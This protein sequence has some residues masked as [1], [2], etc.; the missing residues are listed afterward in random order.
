MRRWLLILLL[1]CV[2]V[3]ADQA[4]ELEQQSQRLEAL[5]AEMAAIS[6]RLERERER[7]GGLEAELARLERRIGEERA[8]LAALDE[9]IRAQAQAVAALGEAVAEAE[10]QAQQ[11]RAFLAATLRAAYRRGEADTL[12]LLLGDV[13]VAER[14]R[15]LVYQRYLGEARA[16]RIRAAQSALETLQRRRAALDS[17]MSRQAAD[18]A[19]RAERLETLQA[20]LA[21]REALLRQLQRRIADDDARLAERRREAEGLTELIETLRARLAEQDRSVVDLPPLSE[22]RGTLG[23]P[24]EGPLLA[25]YGSQRAG[26]LRWSG[27]LIGAEAGAPVHPIAAG[28]V[29]FADWLRGVGLLLIID[30][31]NGYMS[32]YGRNQA[33]Y[34]DVGEAVTPEDVIATVGRSGGRQETGLYFEL[35]ANGE[36]VDPLAWLPAGT[37]R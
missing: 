31:G 20:G 26:D 4:D 36:P 22:A 6:E 28:Q 5:R 8:A 12:R 16:E 29:V 15:L 9:R 19:A 17:V 32:L 3:H 23:W 13:D 25:R 35:R 34:F 2:P 11:H 30:H 27:M 10:Q 7:A 1:A 18:R 37:T 24:V 33:L 14:Q 21:E